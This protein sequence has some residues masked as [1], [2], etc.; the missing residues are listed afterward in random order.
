MSDSTTTAKQGEGRVEGVPRAVVHKKI[1]DAAASRPEAAMAELADDVSGAT[2]SIVERV[3]GEYGD[4]AYPLE[5]DD[6]HDEP[7]GSEPPGSTDPETDSDDPPMSEHEFRSDEPLD[8]IPDPTAV[9]EKQLETLREIHDRPDATQAELAEILGVS[10]AT[11]NQRVNAIDGFDWSRRREFVASMFG[12]GGDGESGDRPFAA[13]DRSKSDANGTDERAD[14]VEPPPTS[15]SVEGAR[16]NGAGKSA[17]E[18]GPGQ[19]DSDSD[20]EGPNAVSAETIEELT[21]RVERVDHRLETLEERL[22]S[23]DP[24]GCGILSD[25]ELAHKVIHACFSAEH[26]T[27]A[28][29]L[30]I[31]RSMTTDESG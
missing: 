16:S 5:G 27:E 19:A 20:R 13:D 24:S 30:R 6:E 3:L 4:P 29:E 14:E 8:P 26:I 25:P 17:L 11:I 15:A 7:P 31:L 2:T 10:S 28:E 1:L 18:G 12:D 23:T 21:G 9:T 22:S